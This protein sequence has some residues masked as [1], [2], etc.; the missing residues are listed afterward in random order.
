MPLQSYK[1]P[2]VYFQ[3]RSAP[4][5][6][7]IRSGVPV[8]IGVAADGKPG[9]VRDITRWEQFTERFGTP[10]PDRYLAYAVRGFFANGGTL[11]HVCAMD[12]ENPVAAEL[13]RVLEELTHD[14]LSEDADLVCAPD[15]QLFPGQETALQQKILDFCRQSKGAGRYLFA[16]L[17]ALP[18]ANVETLL[19]QMG[20]LQGDDGA[21]YHPWIRVADGPAAGGGFI[22]PCGHLAGIYSR[23]DAATGVHKAPANDVV[24][25]ALDLAVPVTEQE[26]ALLN[27]ENVNCLRA[28]PGRGIRVWGARTVSRDPAWRYVNVRRLFLAV[29]RRIERK[30]AAMLFEPNDSALWLR[31]TRE[32]GSYLGELYRKGAFHGATGE[33]AYYVKCDSETNSPDRR[34]RGELVVEVGMAAAVPG[35]FIIVRI[36]QSDGRVTVT[37]QE[38]GFSGG[39]PV[40]GHNVSGT[41][42]NV[43]IAAIRENPPGADLL[44][45][46][47]T[48]ANRG[49]IPVDMTNWVLKD[50]AGHQFVFPRFVF[51]PGTEV[52][53]WT[54]SGEDSVTDLYWG[55]GA[56]LWNNTG[57][58]AYLYDSQDNEIATFEYIRGIKESVAT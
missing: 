18:L 40:P 39:V 48:L 31:I 36:V 43:A 19:Q 55:H 30:M 42:P 27:P 14:P 3:E 38:S 58:T 34:D 35:E 21:L 8:F 24:A 6:A 46:H 45:E 56:P 9:V 13:D 28:F 17:D 4:R 32:L 44:Q 10:K 2:G 16:I 49:G 29:C 47:L 15:L 22:P 12:R 53:I 5:E 41:L 23:S 54:R 51:Q 20:A 26:Q 52:R 1:T 37:P 7:T 11:C 57:D 33:E 25:E 50:R